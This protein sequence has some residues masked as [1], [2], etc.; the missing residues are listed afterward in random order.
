MTD[1]RSPWH[2]RGAIA[3]GILLI[4]IALWP[5][6]A[7]ARASLRLPWNPSGDWALLAMRVEDVGH[8][9]PLLGPYSRFGWNHP[10]PLM[11]WVLAVPYHLAGGAAE[12][13]L[14]STAWVNALA[15]GGSVG[16]AWRR[17]RLPLAASTTVA[18]MILTRAIGPEQLRDPWNPYITMLP[19]ALFVFLVWS[20]VEG[21]RWAWPLAVLVDGNRLP[22][23]LE[24]M[25]AISGGNAVPSL[26]SYCKFHARAVVKGD[27][28]STAIAAASVVAKVTRD[29]IMREASVKWPRYSFDG[30]KG[31]GT[32]AHVAAIRRYG[33]CEIHRRSFEP[34]RSMVGWSRGE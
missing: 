15:L 13:L 25:G 31:Y 11:F 6:L 29:R 4:A 23:Q 20:G 1:E 10:G 22:P 16:V 26:P 34:I 12:A 28:K 33:P 30:H 5:A 3:V 19:L 8:V 9:T 24:Q 17:G 2:R 14:A 32:A 27:A 7:A 18:L 21:D